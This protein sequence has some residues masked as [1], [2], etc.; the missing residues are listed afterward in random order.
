MWVADDLPNPSIGL[1]EADH[2]QRVIPIILRNINGHVFVKPVASP[3]QVGKPAKGLNHGG[4]ALTHQELMK[5]LGCVGCR[6]VVA[7]LTE[8][9]EGNRQKS[10]PE[11]QN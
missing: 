11:S 3:N 1:G 8:D 9:G 10:Y 4:F 7:I 6:S 2:R 5:L